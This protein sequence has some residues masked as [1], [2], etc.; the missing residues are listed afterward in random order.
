MLNDAL[1]EKAL[2]NFELLLLHW[3]IQFRKITEYEYDILASWRNDTNFGSCR[4]NTDKARGADFAG[5]YITK[6]EANGFGRGFDL[7]DFTGFTQEGQAKIG[8]DVI[9]LCQRIYTCKTYK[10]ACEYLRDDLKILEKDHKLIIP[11]QEEIERRKKEQEQKAARLKKYAV[12]LW[13]S[14]KYHTLA[15]SIGQK[16]LIARGINTLDENIRFHPKLIYTPNKTQY[17]ALIF[18]VQVGPN[19]ELIAIHRIYLENNGTKARVDNPKMALASVKGA[20]IWFG[21]PSFT[22][23]I[24]EGPENALSL[25]EM[26]ADFVVSTI[27]GANLG[28]IKIPSNVKT[29]VI[30]PDPDIAGLKSL[31][32]AL[33]SYKVYAQM[34]IKIKELIIPKIILPS[35]KIADVNN[36]LMGNV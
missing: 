36:I 1:R 33:E 8:F 10:A 24:T 35:G 26:G 34:G 28:G 13:E 32:S 7:S 11:S 31:T 6:E 25:R 14:S 17:P 4:F 18:K 30:V 2:A 12:D 16:Y 3:K 9:G 19:K 5:S 23:Y 20:G 27:F 15:G 22:L 29:I 21:A